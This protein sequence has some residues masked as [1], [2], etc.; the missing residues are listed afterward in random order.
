MEPPGKP[1][2]RAGTC[3][4]E[5]DPRRVGPPPAGGRRKTKWVYAL[6]RRAKVHGGWSVVSLGAR[7]A[8]EDRKTPRRKNAEGG[9]LNQIGATVCGIREGLAN[10]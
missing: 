4:R 10:V 5:Q 8:V 7:A 2:P 3:R 6:Q 9:A 1:D